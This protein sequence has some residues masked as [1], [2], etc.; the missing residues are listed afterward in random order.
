MFNENQM[1]EFLLT[2]S[3]VTA[4]SLMPTHADA[5]AGGD[6]TAGDPYHIATCLELQDMDTDLDASYILTGDIDCSATTGWNAGAGF[7]PVGDSLTPFA[8]TLDGQG[9]VISDLSINID[10][11]SIGLFGETA[12]GAEIN[13][14]G[15]ENT[16]Y[17]DVSGTA[18][19]RMGGLVGNNAGLVS[20]SYST[21]SL[22]ANNFFTGGLVGGNTGTIINS[23]SKASV[24]NTDLRAAG[25]SGSNSGT[26]TNSYST[27]V[28]SGGGVELGLVGIN[29]GTVTD[30]FWDTE[31]SGQTTSA[32]GTGKTTSEM[33]DVSTFTD[34]DTAGL[35]TAWDF[36]G[37]PND[38]EAGTDDWSIDAAVNGGYPFLT[39]FVDTV[40]GIP[41][42]LSASAVS[43]TQVDLSWSVPAYDGNGTI[44]GYQIERKVAAGSFS[45]LV[46]DTGSTATTYQDTGLTAETLY[47]YRV[48]AINAVGTSSASTEAFAT[49][50]KPSTGSVINFSGS[51]SGN[52]S[53]D[54][55]DGTDEDETSEENED[56][57]TDEQR[58]NIQRQINEIREMIQ[59]L[60]R[61]IEILFGIQVN[62][63]F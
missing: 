8:G 40:P 16:D 26:I 22:A 53:D 10:I 60:I 2:L 41:T 25:L 11:P 38:D 33:K 63:D 36:L 32:G 27:G 21:G 61:L 56:T 29:S 30:S 1:K 3:I 50:P 12:A 28:I 5:F 58:E 7:A 47:T 24:T 23:Y 54:G 4:I 35:T 51:S 19:S 39:A 55:P 37:N 49:T 52:D 59:E 34:T 62:L 13:N 14:V 46:A 57:L 31:T 9:F 43:N 48:S 20:N 17:T 44:T 18:S 15:L 42:A 6:G 45:T